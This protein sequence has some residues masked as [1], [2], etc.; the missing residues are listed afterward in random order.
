MTDVQVFK[1][2][3]KEQGIMANIR[4]MYYVCSPKRYSISRPLNN[5]F[6]KLSFEEWI[7]DLVTSRGFYSLM[8]KIAEAYDCNIIYSEYDYMIPKITGMR[9]EGF[10]KAMKRWAYFVTNNVV[11]DDVSIK[12]GD[13]V[14]YKNPFKWDD[15][16]CEMVVIDEIN[17]RDGYVRGHLDGT[18]G[19]I[20]ENKRDYMNL[21]QLRKADNIQEPIE[22]SYSIKRN[23]R[24]YNGVNK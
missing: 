22:I 18:D 11:I 23:R 17:I 8:Y 19:S 4:G 16:D 10:T 15:Q 20:W 1:W 9:T 7:H 14:G 2:F 13:V 5:R 12:A 6:Y 3:C 21:S 24:V